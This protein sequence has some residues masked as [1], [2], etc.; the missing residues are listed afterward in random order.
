[1]SRAK[2]KDKPLMLTEWG[3]LW[4]NDWRAVDMLSTASY[5]ALNDLDALFFYSYNGGWAMSW[6]NLEKKLYYDTVIF[7]DPAKMGLFPLGALIFLRGDVRTSL[8]TYGVSYSLDKLF[9]MVDPHADRM[10]LAG[11]MYASRLEKD[12]YESE[13]NDSGSQEIGYPRLPELSEGHRVTSDTGEIIRDPEKGV[14]IL[15]TPRTVSFSGFT[16]RQKKQ[17]F[18]GLGFYTESDFAT[19]TATSLDGRDI[20]DS[21]HL[22]IAAVGR[23]R[24]KDQ[25]LAP[26][27]TKKHDDLKKDVYILN[28]GKGPILVEGI[29][30]K[31]VIKGKGRSFRVFSLDEKGLRREEIPVERDNNG[32]RFNISGRDNTIYYEIVRK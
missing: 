28:K 21:R 26:H 14:F 29:D 9:N 4:P 24:N 16:G 3:T 31:V 15:E 7:N 1:M 11:I 12:F 17:E 23:V 25:R 6:D 10:K 20:V 18:E 2:V 32:Y 8:N 22:L 27:I 30:A 19:F 5:A 13:G